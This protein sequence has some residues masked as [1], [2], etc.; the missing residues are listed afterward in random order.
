MCMTRDGLVKLQC[1]LIRSL[2]DEV[3][4]CSPSDD[5]TAALREQI[6]EEEARLAE[7]A[8]DSAAT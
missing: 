8:D 7:L 4:R 5:R 2:S 6:R 1:A 3:D